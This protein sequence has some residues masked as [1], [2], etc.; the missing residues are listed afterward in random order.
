MLLVL[1]FTVS[2]FGN[3][4]GYTVDGVPQGHEAREADRGVVAI[5]IPWYEDEYR[6]FGAGEEDSAMDFISDTVGYFMDMVSFSVDGMPH[7]MSIIFLV[8]SLLVLFILGCAVR[9]AG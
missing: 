7:E 6:L 4:A 3:Y 2:I 8:M 5:D 9:G 1:I